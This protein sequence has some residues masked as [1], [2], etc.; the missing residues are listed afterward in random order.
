MT[1]ETETEAPDKLEALQDELIAS[2]YPDAVALVEEQ[3][4]ALQFKPLRGTE[5]EQPAERGPTDAANV[6]AQQIAELEALLS[7]EPEAGEPEA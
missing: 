1:T 2:G 6:R 7:A 5:G 4:F 3:R